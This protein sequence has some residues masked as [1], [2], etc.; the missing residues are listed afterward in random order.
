MET[1]GPTGSIVRKL[2]G[3]DAGAQF[4][5]LFSLEP[6]PMGWDGTVSEVQA[7]EDRRVSAVGRRVE[8]K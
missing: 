6:Q 7:Q 2:R 5:F 1:A 3:I 8:G 4:T